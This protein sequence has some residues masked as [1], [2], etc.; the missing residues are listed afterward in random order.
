MLGEGDWSRL[1]AQRAIFRER[2]STEL[3]QTI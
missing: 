3:E 2:V 1:T